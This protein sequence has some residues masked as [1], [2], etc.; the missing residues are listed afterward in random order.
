MKIEFL[1]CD[2]LVRKANLLKS[3]HGLTSRM[4]SD[5]LE[6]RGIAYQRLSDEII[7]VD[8]S[9]GE[10]ELPSRDEA[11]EILKMAHRVLKVEE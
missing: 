5:E 4:M 9:G 10:V 1:T 8:T 3:I 6:A 2:E 7:V 11:K